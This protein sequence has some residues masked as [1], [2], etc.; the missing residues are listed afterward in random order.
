M[1]P[2]IQ[3]LSSQ[4]HECRQAAALALC[5]LGWSATDAKDEIFS[6]LCSS[7]L[8]A[9]GA[10]TAPFPFARLLESDQPGE[11]EAAAFALHMISQVGN[12][13]QILTA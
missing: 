10:S 8:E 12:A 3:L 2:L 6:K 7:A 11:H 5:F 9:S 13:P 1:E 4:D